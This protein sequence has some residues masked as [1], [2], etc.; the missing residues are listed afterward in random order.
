MTSQYDQYVLG[1]P[2]L[3]MDDLTYTPQQFAAALR[4]LSPMTDASLDTLVATRQSDASGDHPDLSVEYLLARALASVVLTRR[5]GRNPLQGPLTNQVADEIQIHYQVMFCR[6]SFE[7]I[8]PEV[9]D[10]G[11]PPTVRALDRATRLL[12]SLIRR[13]QIIVDTT[14]DRSQINLTNAVFPAHGR[15]IQNLTRQ[16]VGPAV[17]QSDHQCTICFEAAETGASIIMLPCNPGH[18]FHERCIADWLNLINTCPIC[19]QTVD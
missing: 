8:P 19:R 1:P 11:H 12:D 16:V 18:W 5:R 10:S 7:Y 4:V 17:T 15:T 14:V 6:D 3:G 2:G 13:A 9:G